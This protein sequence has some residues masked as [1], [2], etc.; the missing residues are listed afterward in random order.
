MA[1]GQKVTGQRQ[2]EF[3]YDPHPRR[4]CPAVLAVSDAINEPRYPSLK[5]II[6]AK[7]KPQEVSRAGRRGR[8][9]DR[10]HGE[11][12]VAHH[13][14]R[15]ST[16]RPR[17]G[18]TPQDRGDGTASAADHGVPDRKEARYEHAGVPGSTTGSDLP[19]G[20]ARRARQGRVAQTTD[21]LRPVLIGLRHR[22][23]G[24]GRGALTG[25]PGCS[26]RRRPPARGA[27]PPA[28]GGRH[29]AA[30][31]TD[32]GFGTVL[33]TAVGAV[34]R[35]SP[36]GSPP[37]WTPA[38]TGTWATSSATTG[39]LVGKRSALGDTVQ[40]DAGWT[41][42]PRLGLVVRAPSTGRERRRSAG[43]GGRARGAG[44]L[45]PAGATMSARRPG[46]A[47]RQVEEA[48]IPG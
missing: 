21:T 44:G 9:G 7:K 39:Q 22:R 2:T 29:Q 41:S 30:W 25:R 35:T 46:G 33:F 31:F 48:D 42:E 12:G 32:Q 47:G 40:V 36:A 1:D 14:A 34:R 26:S 24:G 43:G 45:A 19:Q 18:D 10:A 23:P 13:G 5:G 15:P 27:P 6:G 4:R 11:A 3:G 16:R 20:A 17:A 28:A 38:S 8:R 37:A